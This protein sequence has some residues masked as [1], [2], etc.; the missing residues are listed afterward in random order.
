MKLMT[1]AIVF[2]VSTSAHAASESC[3]NLF[4]NVA[5]LSMA[6]GQVKGQTEVIE[7]LQPNL[8]FDLS[9]TV[10]SLKEAEEKNAPIL[11]MAKDHLIISCL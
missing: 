6:L 5:N 1:L 7:V 11:Q 8:S 4:N 3:L 9:R 10:Q 2:A